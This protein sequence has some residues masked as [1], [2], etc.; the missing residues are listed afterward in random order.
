MRRRKLF[1]LLVSARFY[2]TSFFVACMGCLAAAD[3][4]AQPAT[5]YF[6]SGDGTTQL[7]G[8]VFAPLNSGPHPAVVML[9]GRAGP[10]SANINEDCTLVARDV[11]SPCNASSLSRRHEAW[12][13]YWADHGYLAL[14]PDSFGPRN[15]GH[16]FGRFSHGDPERED[17]N[18]R[19]VRP[20]DA[21]GALSYLR[22]RADVVPDRIFL[23]GWSNGAST[24]LNV[25][26]RQATKPSG[27]FRAAMAL[28]PGCGAR[29]LISGDYKTASPVTVF[30][31]SDDEEV[32]PVNCRRV[33]DTARTN[34]SPIDIVDYAG[35]THDFDDPG[36]KRQSIEANRTARDDVLRRA[37]ALF[38]R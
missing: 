23:Q 19:S 32:S 29:A 17:V 28:Y 6:A 30:L 34:G 27:G 26:Y 12:G 24:V 33:L 31:A 8:Y 20:L 3:A 9:H 18:E 16:G 2:A 4:Q 22:S 35:A 5:V 21:E 15:K 11:S 1:A 38:A 7:V 25:M 37:S 10:Y 13:N 36:K 14:L